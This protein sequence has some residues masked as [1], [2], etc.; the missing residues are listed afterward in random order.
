M[1]WTMLTCLPSSWTT[2]RYELLLLHKAG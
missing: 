1:H 2:S